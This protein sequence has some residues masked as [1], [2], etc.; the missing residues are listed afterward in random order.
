MNRTPQS[1]TMPGGAHVYDRVLLDHQRR[2]RSFDQL[3]HTRRGRE[4]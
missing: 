4:G 1:L 2:S 3:E